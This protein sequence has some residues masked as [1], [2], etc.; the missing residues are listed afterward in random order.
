MKNKIQV[1]KKLFPQYFNFCMSLLK[2]F[3]PLN[4][5]SLFHNYGNMLSCITSGIMS[6]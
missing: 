4:D 3:Q 2:Q 6:A 5:Q 1:E